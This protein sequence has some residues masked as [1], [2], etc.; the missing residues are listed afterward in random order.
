MTN[1]QVTGGIEKASVKRTVENA[2]KDGKANN[3]AMVINVGT[4]NATIKC[5]DPAGNAATFKV[6]GGGHFIA[7]TGVSA[8]G[9][10]VTLTDPV[11]GGKQYVVSLDVLL[12]NNI[13][14]NNHLQL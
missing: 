2:V 1:F 8:D 12:N 5:K 4:T 14:R 11:N 10:Y 3:T 7:I 13:E 6:T 9:K